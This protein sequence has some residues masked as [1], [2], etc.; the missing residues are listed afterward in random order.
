M[1]RSWSRARWT[2]ARRF[3]SPAEV[4]T[5]N[6]MRNDPPVG[7]NRDRINDHPRIVFATKGRINPH[8]RCL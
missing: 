1:Q 8:R 4:A 5:I 2:A 3:G 7:Y 6:T